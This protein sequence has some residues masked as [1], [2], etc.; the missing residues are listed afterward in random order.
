MGAT[1]PGASLNA[2]RSSDQAKEQ[3]SRID[4][5]TSRPVSS[6]PSHD[7]PQLAAAEE[8]KDGVSQ[9]QLGE[10]M[11][12]CNNVLYLRELGDDETRRD[13]NGD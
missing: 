2:I 12:R 3:Q 11:I 9:G 10:I 7:V 8:Y 1:T 6:P 4:E 5:L 13:T